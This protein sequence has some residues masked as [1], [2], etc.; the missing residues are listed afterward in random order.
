MLPVLV[1]AP[2]YVRAVVSA[3]NTAS[4]RV[5]IAAYLFQPGSATEP[6]IT[7]L[8]DA[9]I[10]G[11]SVSII[12]DYST[13][14]HDAG[15]LVPPHF[16]SSMV[17]QLNHMSRQLR[18]HGV[19]IHW[20]G[21]GTLAF[22]YAGRTHSKWIV[23]D[24]TVFCFGG[25]NLDAMTAS[26]TDYMIQYDDERL[27]DIIFLEHQSIVRADALATGTTSSD[28]TIN[29]GT[30]LID[31][32]IPGDSVIY[33]RALTLAR[34]ARHITLV[35][36][37]CPSGT[38]ASTIGATS[39]DIYYNQPSSTELLTRLLIS[40]NQHRYG[41]RSSYH[42][43]PYLHAKFMIVTDHTGHKTAITGS[44]NFISFGGLLGTREIALET[45]DP[46]LISQ[47]ESFLT[48]YVA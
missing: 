7:A 45:S 3:I 41:V 30:V 34:S 21:L 43:A 48:R 25:I 9:A 36:Q 17:R 12:A 6:I 23:A 42:R 4:S 19:D 32:G 38:L 31:G 15:A 33:R 29:G 37:Y 47:L 5:C 39:H 14:F 35:S 22:L 20:V 2:S 26:Y 28:Y 1:P 18:D 27:A 44:H 11:V 16:R 8:K 10:R 40:A 46:H 24:S 13:Y